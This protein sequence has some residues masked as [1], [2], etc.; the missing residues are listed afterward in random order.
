MTITSTFTPFFLSIP[1]Y[2]LVYTRLFPPSVSDLLQQE[3]DAAKRNEEGRELAEDIVQPKGNGPS[4]PGGLG[5]D[6]ATG[7]AR[8]FNLAR[9]AVTTY[10][11]ST[12]TGPQDDDAVNVDILKPHVQSVVNRVLPASTGAQGRKASMEGVAED[13]NAGGKKGKAVDTEKPKPKVPSKTTKLR[14]KWESF[15]VTHGTGFIVVLDDL[16][17]GHVV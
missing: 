2:H 17:V 6:F 15:K 9:S 4:I 14:E 16:S 12:E 8:R 3:A 1:L 7:A 11:S 5:G 13:Q 10:T